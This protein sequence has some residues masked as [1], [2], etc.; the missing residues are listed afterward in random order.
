MNGE[1]S[2]SAGDG[3]LTTRE[4]VARDAIAKMLSL[5]D[6]PEPGLF[7]WCEALTLARKRV[8]EALK[9]ES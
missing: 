4:L 6:N 5:L 2:M 9:E 3:Q 8:L 7:T 1:T